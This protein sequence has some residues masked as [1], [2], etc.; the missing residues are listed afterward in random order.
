MHSNAFA[1]YH[2]FVQFLFFL[3]VMLFAMLLQHPLLV[4]IGLMISF[5]TALCIGGRR[6]LMFIL[7]M[8]VP[9]ALLIGIINPLF[10]HAGMTIL[11]YFPN[12]NPFTAESL[13]YGFVSGGMF[14]TVMLWC[15][16]LWKTVTSDKILYLFGRFTP[17]TGLL[18]SMILRFLPQ[19][20]SQFKAVRSAQRCLGRDLDQ[21]NAV[22]RIRNTVRILSSVIGWSLEHGIETADS[23]KSRGYGTGRRSFFSLYHFEKRDAAVLVVELFCAAVAATFLISERLEFFYFPAL[24]ELSFYWQD[25][26]C[27]LSY[28][29]LC[30][31]PLLLQWKEVR[32]WNALRSKI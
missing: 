21:G 22:R 25:L 1:D 28:I 11:F 6:S 4:L 9:S 14:C 12:G 15:L 20:A 17:K 10:N 13:I 18:L 24:S 23:L 8:I 3:I 5:L 26:S 19:F 32:V 27:Y 2:P 16:C 31:L 29:L 30:M 7:K